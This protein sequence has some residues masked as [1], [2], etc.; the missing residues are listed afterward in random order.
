MR[1]GVGLPAIVVAMMRL[2]P[3]WSRLKG[4]A[5]TLPYDAAFGDAYQEGRPLPAGRWAPVTVPTLVISRTA[6]GTP[7]P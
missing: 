2:M 4:V 1:E 7:S 6:A 3:A 5:H